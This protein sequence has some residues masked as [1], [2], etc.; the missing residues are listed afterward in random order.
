M[1]PNLE[2]RQEHLPEHHQKHHPEHLVKNPA[3][4]RNLVLDQNLVRH[5]HQSLD[6]L[7][8]HL[9]NPSLLGRTVS[10]G[11]DLV[12]LNPETLLNQDPNQS[13]LQGH[14]PHHRL[15]L[16]LDLQLNLDLDLQL[17]L[18]LVHHQVQNLDRSRDLHLDLD[19]LV[20]VIAN[21]VVAV[22]KVVLRVNEQ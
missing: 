3:L 9:L 18:G 15:N 13:H 11:Q 14:D 2:H 8:V 1:K 6:L 7:R 16:V 20:A 12:L 22:V 4:V 10:P 17:N 19:Q 5:H 21:P